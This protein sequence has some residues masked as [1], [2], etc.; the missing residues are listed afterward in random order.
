MKKMMIMAIVLYLFM[1]NGLISVGAEI[2]DAEPTSQGQTNQ[3]IHNLE[4]LDLW[5]TLYIVY[6]DGMIDGASENMHRALQGEITD[7]FD[8]PTET[9]ERYFVN[10]E[11]YLMFQLANQFTRDLK[12]IHGG[13]PY[14]AELMDSIDEKPTLARIDLYR[15]FRHAYIRKG[16][17]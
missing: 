3:G 13:N 6:P 9:R 8:F 14:M 5:G 10:H 7:F 17:M 2:G 16:L 11:A 12:I 1:I 4:Q 15:M